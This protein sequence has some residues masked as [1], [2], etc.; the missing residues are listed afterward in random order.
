MCV[1]VCM[2]NIATLHGHTHMH[3]GPCIRPTPTEIYSSFLSNSMEYD[4]KDSFSFIFSKC[5]CAHATLLYY[6]HTRK[7]MDF[8]FWVRPGE[9]LAEHIPSYSKSGQC[10]RTL[11]SF[12][13]SK[14]KF[15]HLLKDHLCQLF[16]RKTL[17]SFQYRYNFFFVHYSD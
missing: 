8:R 17:V 1:C 6:T 10:Y 7:V 12:L 16:S 14:T 3:T 11:R 9:R 4:S 2:C 13:G 5:P 15:V